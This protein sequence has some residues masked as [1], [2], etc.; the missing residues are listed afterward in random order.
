MMEEIY[1]TSSGDMF[2]NMLLDPSSMGDPWN[3]TSDE[4]DDNV[5]NTTLPDPF[6]TEDQ[7]L[8]IATIPSSIHVA[9]GMIVSLIG[10]LGIICNA[11]VLYVFS[12]FVY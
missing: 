6:W 8:L 12:R 2:R 1:S 5:T 3:V 11:L 7:L 10:F 9:L 4:D